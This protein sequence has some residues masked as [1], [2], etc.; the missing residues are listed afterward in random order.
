[1]TNGL[2]TA[3]LQATR[4]PDDGLVSLSDT[5]ILNYDFDDT[6]LTIYIPA[7]A[8]NPILLKSVQHIVRTAFAGGTPAINIG[9]GTD[10]DA[11]ITA[12]EITEATAGN[13]ATSYGGAAA[14][15]DGMYFT[16]AGTVVVTL[17]ASLSAGAGT[18]LV[19]VFRF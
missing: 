2:L 11:F 6:A 10:T 8:A 18:V 16:A 3:Q 15:A 7:T 5:L 4:D 19:E 14:S 9:D 12:A 13:V 1:M 17:S